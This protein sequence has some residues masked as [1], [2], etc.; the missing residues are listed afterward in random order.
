V[1]AS[2]NSRTD[3]LS[4]LTGYQLCA[5]AEGKSPSTVRI[6]ASSVG[7]FDQFLRRMERPSDAALIGPT[8]IRAFI[9]Y[10]GQKPCFTDHPFAR[11]QAHKLSDHSVNCYLRSIRAFWS[12]LVAEEIIASSPFSRVKLPRVSRKVI[13]TFTLNQIQRLLASID[14]ASHCGYRDY[15]IIL[16]LLDTGLRVSELTGLKV[17]DVSFEEGIFKVLGKGNKERFVPFGREV[18]HCL[19]RY[20]QSQRPDP[21]RDGDYLFLTGDGRQLT[22]NRVEGIMLGYARKSDLQGVRCSPH[23]LRHTAAISFLRN[24]GD[25]FSLQRMLGHSSLEM[26]RRYCEIA[27]TDVKRAHITASPVDNWRLSGK[28]NMHHGQGHSSRPKPRPTY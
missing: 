1:L 6:V 18:Q 5:R 7:Y 22:K 9:L 11:E 15:T 8:E 28:T 12:W 27:D 20:C 21:Q 23:T 3:L 19:W 25:V 17:S 4:L 16:T 26:T 13:K 2:S 24:H 14:T 10:L